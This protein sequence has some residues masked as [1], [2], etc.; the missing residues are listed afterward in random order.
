MRSSTG[1]LTCWMN[2]R[3]RM[4]RDALEALAALV[5]L[6]RLWQGGIFKK[7]GVS[8]EKDPPALVAAEAALLAPE[9]VGDRTKALGAEYRHWCA[10]GH[11]RIGL[12]DYSGEGD[13]DCPLCLA[14][15]K[16]SELRTTEG[17]AEHGEPDWEAMY[18]R[19]LWTNHGF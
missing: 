10:K 4:N 2:G 16:I 3:K 5:K 11:E 12:L 9:P 13:D 17:S 7:I 14:N 15:R 19:L 1:S 18:R 6:V 8:W